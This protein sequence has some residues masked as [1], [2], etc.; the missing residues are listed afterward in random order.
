M[1]LYGTKRK[2]DKQQKD[3]KVPGER[4]CRSQGRVTAGPWWATPAWLTAIISPEQRPQQS[5]LCGAGVG[6]DE[7]QAARLTIV[8]CDPLC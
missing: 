2:T 8:W 7:G 4:L 6:A 1:G 3:L 5:M